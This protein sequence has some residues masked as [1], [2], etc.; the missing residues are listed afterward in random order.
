MAIKRN[1]KPSH[2]GEF[3]KEFVLAPHKAKV[4]DVAEAVGVSRPHLSQ[5]LNGRHRLDATIAAK[6]GVVFGFDPTPVIRMQAARDAYDAKEAVKN[7][8]PAR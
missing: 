6:L 3:I 2:P 1:R 4:T 8:K 7:W 5:I